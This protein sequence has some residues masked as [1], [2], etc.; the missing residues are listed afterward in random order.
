MGA[1]IPSNVTCAPPSCVVTDRPSGVS[2]LATGFA[3]PIPAGA[4]IVTIIPG[5]TEPETKLAALATE[6]DCSFPAGCIS[7]KL[8]PPIVTVPA[9]AS[10]VFQGTEM[11]TTPAPV[12]D[13]PET[14][15]I[16]V[17]EATAVQAQPA[18]AAT[19]NKAVPPP[20]G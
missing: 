11:P 2:G 12:P 15:E 3:G 4:V 13:A 10:L 7:E 20:A 18:G 6:S 1:A 19:L 8:C 14:I 5:E 16:Q 17:S 9:L